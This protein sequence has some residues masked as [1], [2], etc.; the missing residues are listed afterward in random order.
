MTGP[1]RRPALKTPVVGSLSPE[2]IE[3]LPAM[4][5]KMGAELRVAV[6]GAG[7]ETG[8]QLAAMAKSVRAS[9]EG[10]PP[11]PPLSVKDRALLARQNRHTGPR[12][13]TKRHRG[14]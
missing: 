10:P 12:G 2:T 11:P 14:R 4:L 3:Q 8:R 7:R 1:E 6:E 5:A 9:R 13:N